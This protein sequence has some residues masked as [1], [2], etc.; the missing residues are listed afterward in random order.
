MITNEL[1]L[2]GPSV[3]L[4]VGDA[5]VYRNP[6]GATYSAVVTDLQPSYVFVG[7]L[8]SRTTRKIVRVPNSQILERIMP[9]PAGV[10]FL[11]I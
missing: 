10:S 1:V 8:T 6:S 11:A 2:S 5:V 9:F 3:F 4:K 7:W